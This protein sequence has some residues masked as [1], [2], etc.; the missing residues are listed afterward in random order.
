MATITISQNG[1]QWVHTNVCLPRP[2]RD[3][4]KQQGISMSRELRKA[5]EKRM[6]RLGN[7]Q[8]QNATNA[9]TPTSPSSTDKQVEQECSSGLE[10]APTSQPAAQSGT[11]W[12]SKDND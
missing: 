1:E 7:A 6:K 10:Q 2:L 11:P 12:G 9:E 5:L 3:F 8:G 4:A